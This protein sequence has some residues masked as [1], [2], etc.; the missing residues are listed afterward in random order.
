MEIG[1]KVMEVNLNAKGAKTKRGLEESKSLKKLKDMM[2]GKEVER[3]FGERALPSTVVQKA[4]AVHPPLRKR[5][6]NVEK[7]E[8]KLRVTW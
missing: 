2:K 7:K 4:C 8:G 5:R 6:L 1:G 3:Y